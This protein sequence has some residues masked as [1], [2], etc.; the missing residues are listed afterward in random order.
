MTA[1]TIGLWT[2]GLTLLAFAAFQGVV[3]LDRTV[4]DRHDV[5]VEIGD[6]WEEH[7]AKTERRTGAGVWIRRPGRN[8]E[9]LESET[10]FA[11]FANSGTQNAR[12]SNWLDRVVSVDVGGR[13][14]AA[15]EPI[16]DNAVWL[17]GALATI[18]AGLGATIWM[19]RRDLLRPWVRDELRWWRADHVQPPRDRA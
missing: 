5:T 10:L 9:R 8:W 2:V 19:K 6:R 7:N 14:V 4:A 11:G 3:I 17:A 16:S 18:V 12:A 1:W 13:S 15:G